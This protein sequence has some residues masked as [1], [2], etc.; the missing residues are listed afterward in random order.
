MAA[1]TCTVCNAQ[2]PPRLGVAARCV[3]R[4]ADGAEWFEC[5]EHGERDN[6]LGSLR[7]AL[8]PIEEWFTA[9]GLPVPGDG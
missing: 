2:R 3:A 4:A 1:R 9:H 5:G 6:V 7:V 8:V